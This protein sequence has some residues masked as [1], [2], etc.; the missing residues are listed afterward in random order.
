MRSPGLEL[1]EPNLPI[2]GL[3]RPNRE[4]TPGKMSSFLDRRSRPPRKGGRE[5]CGSD[6]FSPLDRPT[7][8]TVPLLPPSLQ[9]ATVLHPQSTGKYDIPKHILV[10]LVGVDLEPLK[11]CLEQQQQKYPELDFSKIIKVRGRGWG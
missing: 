4:A 6:P 8:P 10:T 5:E 9:I 1:D 2:L 3:G 11:K 7:P